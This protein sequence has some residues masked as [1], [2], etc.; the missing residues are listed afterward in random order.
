[1]VQREDVVALVTA[2]G[3]SARMG[4]PKALVTWPRGGTMT[5]LEHQLAALSGLRDVV[6]VTGA[7]ALDVPRPARAVHNERWAEG[8]STSIEAGA[9]AL[10]DAP[11][12]IVCA[13]D[14]PI[15]PGVLVALL[16]SFGPDDVVLEPEHEG[17]RGHPLVLAGTLLAALRRASTYDEG[18]RGVVRA[19]RRRALAVTSPLIHL[20][21]N[22][23]EDLV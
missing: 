15:D 7:H 2:A 16:E 4:T 21:L 17:R 10:C 9:L 18:L 8:R 5:L 6:V 12:V 14:Q 19:H 1:M 3:A 13:V 23:P 20:D 11:A 22:T